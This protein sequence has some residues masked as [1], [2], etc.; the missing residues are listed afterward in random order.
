MHME[1]DTNV[2]PRTLRHCGLSAHN[3]LH[4]ISGFSQARLENTVGMKK[5]FQIAETARNHVSSS[6]SCSG[7]DLIGT[8]TAQ[9]H[10]WRDSI[11]DNGAIT[12]ENL[13]LWHTCVFLENSTGR[14]QPS[15]LRRRNIK[16]SFLPQPIS[17]TLGVQSAQ[18]LLGGNLAIDLPSRLAAVLLYVL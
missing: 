18:N 4:V 9:V 7:I 14:D 2:P 12:D 1:H 17:L 16:G 3:S 5:T 10:T 6:L 11:P 15:I 8:S 13:N